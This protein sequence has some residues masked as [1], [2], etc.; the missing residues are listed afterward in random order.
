M[1]IFW[2]ILYKGR[3]LSLMSL[4]CHYVC[5]LCIVKFRLSR[6]S[7]ILCRIFLIFRRKLLKL[8]ENAFRYGCLAVQIRPV[9]G[10]QRLFTLFTIISPII[11]FS[12]TY[13]HVYGVICAGFGLVNEF[14]DH[15]HT[16]LRT[17]SNYSTTANLH[18]LQIT[19]ANTKSSP[20]CSVFNSRFLTTVS[21][22]TD[23]S[24]SRSHVVIFILAHSV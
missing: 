12:Y 19:A 8:E 21:N 4:F 17:T 13:F 5:L 23:S 24:A 7:L 16:P 15:L 11:N 22:S 2:E 3:K 6:I 14:V 1:G 20:A 18:T 10:T 9:C